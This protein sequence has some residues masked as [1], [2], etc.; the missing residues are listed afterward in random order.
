M[1]IYL[2][3]MLIFVVFSFSIGFLLGGNIGWK[4][5]YDF[6]ERN[7][8]EINKDIKTEENK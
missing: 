6:Y 7:K 4:A 1:E 2:W 8:D 5:G 3:L